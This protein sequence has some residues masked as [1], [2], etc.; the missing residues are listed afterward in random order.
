MTGT[1]R[2]SRIPALHIGPMSENVIKAVAAFAQSKSWPICLIASRRQIDSEAIG[3]GYV[4]TTECFAE[5]VA[6]A[7]H[8]GHVILARDHGGP[9]QRIEESLLSLDDAMDAAER[10]YRADIING[11]NIIHIDP[12]KCIKAGTPN[13]LTLFTELTLQLLACCFKILDQT[14]RSDVHFE[15]GSDEGIGMEFTPEQWAEFLERVQTFCASKGRPNPIAIAVPL[16]TKVKELGNCGGLALNPN[17]PYWTKRVQVMREIAERFK[18]KLKLH[19]ADYISAEV[20]KAYGMLG[21][22]Q[23]NVAPELGVRETR[24]LLDFL[25]SHHMEKQAES[26]LKIAYD[27]RKW[28]RWL[29]PGTKTTEEEK[30]IIAGHYVFS[31]PEYIALKREIEA[32]P[33]ATQLDAFLQNAI[34]EGL[35]YYYSILKERTPPAKIIE[36]TPPSKIPSGLNIA[37]V[38]PVVGEMVIISERD[39]YS[40]YCYH[41]APNQPIF[42]EHLACVSVFLPLL[43]NKLQEI[44]VNGE[45]VSAGGSALAERTALKIIATKG[46][47]YVLVAGNK[48]PTPDAT[49]Q[50]IVHTAEQHYKVNKPWGHELWINGE[51][52]IFCFKEVF[53]KQGSQTSLQYHNFKIETT[54]LYEGICD[55]VYK[56]NADVSNDDV[57]SSDLAVVQLPSMTKM[58]VDP[59]TLHRMRAVQDI[60]H[61]EV[62][63]PQLDD[64]IRV[65]DDNK[66][67]HG[68]ISGEHTAS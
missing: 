64:V 12:E 32:H 1:R 8:A 21:V 47:G 42:I 9:Y 67:G 54:L 3:G 48:K 44:T 37:T 50:L 65:Q 45:V 29:I 20:L 24:A 13:A 7:V 16:G 19:N 34:T 35:L 27:S 5:C 56:A 41:L 49:R 17:D 28:E 66:R 52:P 58:C 31:M 2:V 11:F 15:V 10:S 43:G 25:R 23:I 40:Y 38:A 36:F 18:I 51:H 62:S 60:Y 53:I 68:R 33:A 59:G 26:F 4:L 63:T 39:E 30:A 14:G 57:R 61:Y 46:S 22:E 6:A 55:M